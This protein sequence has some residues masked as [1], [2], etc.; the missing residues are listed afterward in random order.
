MRAAARA[1]APIA[2]IAART[3]AAGATDSSLTGL[4]IGGRLTKWV[5]PNSTRRARLEPETRRRAARAE[6]DSRRRAGDPARR[7]A[8]LGAL[9][10]AASDAPIRRQRASRRGAGPA[11]P[12]GM[13]PLTGAAAAG[14]APKRCAFLLRRGHLSAR[15]REELRV[16]ETTRSPCLAPPGGLARLGGFGRAGD[17]GDVFARHTPISAVNCAA[18]LADHRRDECGRAA[19]EAASRLAA[20]E[21]VA[22]GTRPRRGRIGRRNRA[23]PRRRADWRRS[24]RAAASATWRSRPVRLGA[25]ADRR[26]ETDRPPSIALMASPSPAGRAIATPRGRPWR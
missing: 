15:M 19:V 20:A 8:S 26:R 25:E 9:S 11:P 24:A 23:A 2:R 12:P 18:A 7:Y 5:A 16:L 6:I 17:E 3:S 22:R 10:S 1:S 4:D 14:A 21:Q 13:R